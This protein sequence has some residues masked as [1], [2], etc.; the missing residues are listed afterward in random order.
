[1]RKLAVFSF[2]FSAAAF[3]CCYLIPGGAWLG[4]CVFCLLLCGAVWLLIKRNRRV[5]STILCA[6]LALGF[7]WMTVYD[8]VFFDPARSLDDTTVRLVATVRDYPR[9]RDYGWQVS[10]RMKTEQGIPVDLILYTDEQGAV[11]RPGD[12][13]ESVTHLTLGTRSSAGEE[14]TYYT[15]K[16]IFLWGKC[17]GLLNIDR[18]EKISVQYWPAYLAQRLKDGIDAAFSEETASLV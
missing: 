5:F 7:L 12:R 8:R 16:G 18:P 14:I 3:A 1:M 2:S 13:I 17:Y 4:L 15:A 9:Q 6:G 10:A 11:L